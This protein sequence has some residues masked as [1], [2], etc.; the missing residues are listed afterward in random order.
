MGSWFGQLVV[1]AVGGAPP[2]RRLAAWFVLA[3]AASG[4]GDKDPLTG[5]GTLVALG[6]GAVVFEV[7]TRAGADVIHKQSG[8]VV[9]ADE[10]GLARFELSPLT[11]LLGDREARFEVASKPS[12]FAAEQ[13]AF[14]GV[15]VGVDTAPLADFT[16]PEETA[17]WVVGLGPAKSTDQEQVLRLSGDDTS[18]PFNK[19]SVGPEGM[20]WVGPPG[21][22]V[23]LGDVGLVLP[24]SGMLTWTPSVEELLALLR[25]GQFATTVEASV[26]SPGRAARRGQVAL[27]P[28]PE[29]H[30]RLAAHFRALDQQAGTL[31]DRG[32]TVPFGLLVRV[33]GELNLL[34]PGGRGVRWR[35]GPRYEQLEFW[36]FE[37]EESHRDA[38]GGECEKRQA[39]ASGLVL[40][41]KTTGQRVGTVTQRIQP[42]LVTTKVTLRR[43]VSGP[44]L[45]SQSFEPRVA[46]C[47]SRVY[48]HASEIDAWAR[49]L[50]R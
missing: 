39:P 41:N 2:R 19:V 48:A 32:P 46:P 44:V 23:T 38:D 50:M 22:R 10:R 6:P 36:A 4:C 29:G 15:D 1:M 31:P 49:P 45:A 11:A 24:E 42:Q 5:R 14:F 13:W 47:E 26:E 17:S 37:E 18:R 40:V 7:Q 34:I 21:T 27:V 8:R 9:R 25:P 12:M 33:T 3:V 30:A 35:A 43:G 28:R 16:P 20:M